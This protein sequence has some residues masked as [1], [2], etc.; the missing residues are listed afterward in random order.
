MVMV[1]WFYLQSRNGLCKFMSTS[2]RKTRMINGGIF[3]IKYSFFQ[4]TKKDNTTDPKLNSNKFFVIH[5]GEYHP[6]KTKDTINNCHNLKYVR[7]MHLKKVSD[8]APAMT[9]KMKRA[10]QRRGSQPQQILKQIIFDTT[11]AIPKA[12]DVITI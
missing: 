8:R 5:H 10:E 2:E 4:H 11:R 1:V 6:N 7:T 9:R 3:G 12:S